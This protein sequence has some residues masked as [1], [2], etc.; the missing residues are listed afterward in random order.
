MLDWFAKQTRMPG[1]FAASLGAQELEFAHGRYSVSGRSAITAYGFRRIEG[2]RKAEL[3]KLAH[4]MRLG[5]YH[6][7][8]LL[9]P[10]EYQLLQVEA[11]NV[12]K[13]ELKSA[14]R[15]R[16]KDLIDYHVDDA[17][18]DVLDI[19]PDDAAGGRNHVMYA[20]AARNDLIQAHIREFDEARIPLTVIDIRETAQRNIAALY[21][22]EERG[23]ALAYFAEDWGLLTINYRKE[24]Y[25]ARRIDLGLQ[26]LGGESAGQDGGAFERVAVEL[27]RTL[28]HFERQFRSIP[29]ARVLIAPTPKEIGLGEFLRTRLG[30]DSRQ[31]DLKEVLSFDGE[32]PDAA[33]QWRLF[34]HFGAALRHEAKAL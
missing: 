7:A 34:H 5:Q 30:I 32:G 14:I 4:D 19:P 15:W 13:D 6:C 26:Q 1:W 31:V 2:E 16:I 24:L 29:V 10:G 8:A 21:E 12:P 23:I 27:Q 9:N 25:L 33:V 18:V 3:H 20:V 28:D 11:P 17:T 22:T